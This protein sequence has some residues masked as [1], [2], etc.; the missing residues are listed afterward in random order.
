MK[1]SS[2]KLIK[3]E[4]YLIEWRD[5]FGYNGWYDERDIDEKMELLKSSTK[6]IGF[7]VKE[8]DGF[9]ILAMSYEPNSKDFAEWGKPMFIPKG[10]ISKIKQWVEAKKGCG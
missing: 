1:T 4:K 7:F 3:G 8:K 5:T 6:T 10:M 9:V 2:P